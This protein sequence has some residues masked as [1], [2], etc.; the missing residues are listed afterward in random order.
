MT[1]KRAHDM[2]SAR[3]HPEGPPEKPPFERPTRKAPEPPFPCELPP[4]AEPY[5]AFEPPEPWPAPVPS[6]ADKGGKSD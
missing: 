1:D 6:K 2:M 4:A 5:P 3:E